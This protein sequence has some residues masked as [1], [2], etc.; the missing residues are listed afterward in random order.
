M[1]KTYT[2][3][4]W[5][6][7]LFQI[8][9]VIFSIL[10]SS[11]WHILKYLLFTSEAIILTAF[12][13]VLLFKCYDVL[14]FIMNNRE[15]LTLHLDADIMS[16]VFIG[17]FIINLIIMAFVYI[18]DGLIFRHIFKQKRDLTDKVI[19]NFVEYNKKYDSFKFTKTKYRRRKWVKSH[20]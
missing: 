8:L 6:V 19:D 7:G 20:R 2:E 13:S 12:E 14:I 18:E 17:L 5:Y 15:P 1:E 3:M 16:F 9:V 4:P 10:F 11:I